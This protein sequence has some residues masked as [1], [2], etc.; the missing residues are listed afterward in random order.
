MTATAK[1]IGLIHG[2]KRDAGLDDDSYRDVLNAVA[3]VR[4]ARALTVDGAVRVIDRLKVLAGQAPREI[5][6]ESRS[7]PPQARG[8]LRLEGPYAAKMRALWLAGWALGI[9]RDRTDEGLAEYVHRQ[10]GLD[11]PNWLRDDRA[12]VSVIEGLKS[13]IARETGFNWT[14]RGG[15]HELK[16]RLV[17][18][19]WRRALDAGAVRRVFLPDLDLADYAG[20]V[21]GR[22]PRSINDVAELTDHELDVVAKAIGGKMARK[23]GM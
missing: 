17:E 21:A 2:L 13:W 15:R 9:V 18:L 23:R 11:H 20:R 12:A 3:G 6:H 10:T 7:R 5:G 8:A 22:P 19:A 1:Q 4:S 14:E 16:V